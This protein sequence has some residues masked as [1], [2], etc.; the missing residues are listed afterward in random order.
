[1]QASLQEPVQ[2]LKLEL[3][4]IKR[5]ITKE[6]QELKA[7]ETIVL[8]VGTMTTAGLIVSSGKDRI[9]VVLKNKVVAEKGQKIAISKKESGRWR[10]AA[11]G[12]A[13]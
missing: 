9:E 12:I 2:K 4:M 5:L 6:L 13:S 1:M 11:F 10:L 8:T 7:N 3:H